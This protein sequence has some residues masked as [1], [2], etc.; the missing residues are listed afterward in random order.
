M[1][2]TICIGWFWNF[3]IVFKC[4]S[5][6]S[7]TKINVLL[8][9]IQFCAENRFSCWKHVQRRKCR[10]WKRFA[11][12]DRN[13]YG[14]DRL[15]LKKRLCFSGYCADVFRAKLFWLWQKIRGSS[16][17]GDDFHVVCMHRN[18][19][20][21]L[22]SMIRQKDSECVVPPYISIFPHKIP[23]WNY[24]LTISYNFFAIIRNSAYLFLDH[25]T[26]YDLQY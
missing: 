21:S 15:R 22:W 26:F 24:K 7:L 11:R 13:M 9:C 17:E 20:R 4:K 16:H 3:L 6:E 12:V 14:T 2:F 10:L 19:N 18:I 25:P 8:F 23:P 5:K 1:Q